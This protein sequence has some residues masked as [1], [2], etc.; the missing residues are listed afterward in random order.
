MTGHYERGLESSSTEVQ[1]ISAWALGHRYLLAG[2]LRT[3]ARF[4]REAIAGCEQLGVR[5]G[6]VDASGLLALIESITRDRLSR[7]V[8]A[9][10]P[11]LDDSTVFSL[12]L[13]GQVRAWSAVG[14]GDVEVAR[15]LLADTADRCL[16]IGDLKWAVS[17]L[18]AL[19]RLGDPG[20][21]L[22]SL[23]TAIAEMDGPWPA[24][25]L[26]HARALAQQ[27]APAL[28]RT[29]SDF[30]ALG[31]A[32][33]A[34]EAAAQASVA[35]D[36]AGD[37]REASADRTLARSIAGRCEGASTPALQILAAHDTLTDA[38]RETAHYAA[39][40]LS[41][42]DIAKHLQLSVRTIESRLQTVYNKL[43]IRSRDALADA[44][45]TLA[46]GND[47]L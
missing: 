47:P 19:V 36:L 31:A 37:S 28:R 29:A 16:R 3:A 23:E 6:V 15:A 27:D 32:L 4:A 43:G 42:K 14:R 40:G 11:E 20:R 7:P 34:A 13:N 17:C 26:R 46:G 5:A 44:L 18:H 12:G 8:E 21:A 10:P 24:L 25:Y 35:W 45:S 39:E 30:D 41:N 2:R 9:G 22:E 1:A 38:E 33:L